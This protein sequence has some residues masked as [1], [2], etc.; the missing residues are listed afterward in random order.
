[1]RIMLAIA[2]ATLINSVASAR[3]LTIAT[4]NL[5]WHMNQT[6]AKDWIKDCG[7]LFALNATS[8][9]WEPSTTGATKTGWE[10]TWGRDAKIK[11]D[12]AAKPPCDVYKSN[13]QTIPVTETAYRKRAEQI[14]NFISASLNIDVLAF[15]EVSGEDAVRDVLPNG[16]ADFEICSFQSFKVQR[17]AIAWKRTLGSASNCAI[18]GTMSLPQLEQSD[19]VRPGLSLMLHIDGKPLRIITVH[20]KSSCV[21]PLEDRGKLDG[22]S[23]ACKILQ[24]Q[25]RPLEAW[26]EAKSSGVPVV[27][28]GDF[29]R[30]LSHEKNKIVQSAVR[31]DGS[32][33]KTPLTEQTR[34]R[35]LYGEVND[36]SP[37]DSSLVLLEPDCP[38]NQAAQEIC[39]RSKSEFLNQN[40]L[41]PL[42]RADSLGCRN[43]IGLDQIMISTQISAKG[44]ASKVSIGRFGGTRPANQNRPDPLLAISDHCPLMA[45][46]TF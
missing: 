41:K 14:K 30:N 11:W 29:N 43:P 35:S 19:Q 12:I 21:S 7:Q 46:I 10:L 45:T 4:W 32:D 23:E 25:V 34:V 8:G 40:A 26:I 33:P 17:M 24:Q 39:S 9:L 31:T 38:V 42:T 22:N 28:M 16:G 3:D 13:F 27:V 44:A 36:H 5:G 37:A 6:E 1:M 15:Q 2:I 20:L 18:E